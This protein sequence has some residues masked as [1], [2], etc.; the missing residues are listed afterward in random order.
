MN[1]AA[2]ADLMVVQLDGH[3]Y[4]ESTGTCACGMPVTSYDRNRHIADCII[5]AMMRDA[6]VVE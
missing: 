5:A 2:L 6:S 3:V 1:L 4:D